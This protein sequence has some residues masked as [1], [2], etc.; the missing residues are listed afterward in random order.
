[1]TTA[2]F[3]Y[4]D[5]TTIA[6]SDV[7]FV[8]PWAKVDSPV[9]SFKLIEKELPVANIRDF[10]SHDFGTDASGFAVFRAPSIE[11]DFTDNSAIQTG[12]YAE[13]EAILREKLSGV[14]KVIIFDH[15]IRKNDP[16][17]ARQPVPQVHVD[18]TPRAAEVRVRKH[19]PEGEAEGL[20]QGR[21]QIINVWRPIGHAASDYPLAVIDWR[22]TK[23]A[24]LVKVD[25]LYPV[26]R[27]KEVLPD[28]ETAMKTE[29]YEVTGKQLMVRR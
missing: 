21:F 6:D 9:S 10:S 1:M 18:Q 17:A 8:K 5:P 11:K 27:D 20:L 15:T 29:G 7:P 12:Y 19:A 13:V 28:P 23:P 16:Q 26:N 3:R 2:T 24:D 22:T 4:A 25:L 14:K